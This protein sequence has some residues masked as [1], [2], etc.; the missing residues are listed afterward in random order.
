MSWFRHDQLWN[1]F[2]ANIHDLE[3]LHFAGG[4]PLVM[5]E[6]L[7]A[8]EICIETGAASKIELTFNTNVTKIPNR[9]RQLWPKFKTVNLLCSID[10]W[11]PLNDYIRHPSKW[12]VIEQNLDLIDREHEQLNLGWATISTTVQIYNIFHLDELIEYLHRR[13]DFIRPMPNLVH[14]TFPDHFNIQFLPD[15]LK[16][17]ALQGLKDLRAQLS[18]RGK[19]SSLNQIDGIVSYMQM[20]KY[21]PYVINEFC[22][23]T[24]AYD[25]LRDED[26]TALIPEMAALIKAYNDGK[27]GSHIELAISRGEQLAERFKNRFR[28]V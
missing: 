1:D 8:L 3:H 22:R 19:T 4:E 15:E 20:A 12:S 23:I 9:H 10:A 24:H 5:P 7:K 14:L 6:V 18:E 11:G 28:K 2:R 13:F 21:S 26:L 25:Q 16:K 27:I 17:I